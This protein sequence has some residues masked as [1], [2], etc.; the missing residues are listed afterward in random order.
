MWYIQIPLPLRHANMTPERE[1]CSQILR[2]GLLPLPSPNGHMPQDPHMTWASCEPILGLS[3]NPPGYIVNS[4]PVA[5]FGRLFRKTFG[6]TTTTYCILSLRQDIKLVPPHPGHRPPE[7]N[8]YCHPDSIFTDASHG[9]YDFRR[10]PQAYDSRRPWMGYH[11]F[12]SEVETSNAELLR[13]YPEYRNTVDYFDFAGMQPNLQGGSWKK[14]LLKQLYERRSGLEV[15]FCNVLSSLGDPSG[16]VLKAEYGDTL[17][18]FDEGDFQD[19]DRWSC[20][21]DGRDALGRTLRYTSE[22]LALVRWFPEMRRQAGCLR[23]LT[24]QSPECS[25]ECAKVS[26]KYMGVW[27]GTVPSREHWHFLWYSN[28]PLFGLFILP[29]N[30]PICRQ[31]IPQGEFHGNEHYRSDAFPSVLPH[32]VMAPA[33]PIPTAYSHHTRFGSYSFV[34]TRITQESRPSPV[35]EHPWQTLE[36]VNSPPSAQFHSPINYYLPY[37]SYLFLDR[38]IIM[39]L[40]SPEEDWER[41]CLERWREIALSLRP[42]GMVRH[43]E[44]DRLAEVHPLEQFIP[45][46]RTSD[47][48]TK[49]FFT[50]ESDG[51]FYWLSKKHVGRKSANRGTYGDEFSLSTP[52]DSLFSFEPWPKVRDLAPFKKDK[53][54]WIEYLTANRDKR[55]YLEKPPTEDMLVLVD[56]VNIPPPAVPVSRLPGESTASAVNRLYMAVSRHFF[57]GHGTILTNYRWRYQKMAHSSQPHARIIYLLRNIPAQPLLHYPH[58]ATVYSVLQQSTLLNKHILTLCSQKTVL[59][60]NRAVVL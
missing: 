45:S 47:G 33:R 57:F 30:H 55:I 37:S 43:V 2:R 60:G 18:F 53:E 40:Q 11:T 50:E 27:V 8:D 4:A 3:S 49:R 58:F 46:R 52:N 9:A 21:S 24:D 44:E 14:D 32:S 20:W 17:P 51:P 6:K 35:W 13:Q 23:S 41:R 25:C 48:L 7:F 5:P 34:S 22:L 29:K 59:V 38:R 10:Y 39:S 26:K 36:V 12:M 19:I 28:L 54:S 42:P 56:K 15:W 16:S 1:L 31:Q